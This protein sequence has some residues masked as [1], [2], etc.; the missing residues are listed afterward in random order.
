MN[1]NARE[2][3]SNVFK[4]LKNFAE[5]TLPQIFHPYVFYLNSNNTYY[6]FL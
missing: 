3:T 6:S 5:D 4:P 1:I 2:K